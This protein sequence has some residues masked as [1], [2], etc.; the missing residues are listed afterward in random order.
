M[1]SSEAIT[2]EPAS[3]ARPTDVDAVV[4]SSLSL[5]SFYRCRDHRMYF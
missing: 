4:L 5:L 3:T 2:L 1:A